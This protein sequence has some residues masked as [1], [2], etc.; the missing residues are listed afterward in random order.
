[1]HRRDFLQTG[2]AA[3]ATG[4]LTPAVVASGTVLDVP[5][6]RAN[7]PAVLKSYTADDHRRRLQNIGVCTQ[8]VR[9]C[10]RKH[11]VTNYLPAQCA[12]NLGEYPCVKPWNPDVYDEQELDRLRDHGIQLVQLFDESNDSLRLFGGSKHTPLNPEGLRRFVAMAHRRGIRVIT[13]LSTGYF[14]YKD[15][16]LKPEWYRQGDGVTVGYWDM[17]RCSPASP[18]WR[19]P[20]APCCPAARR[21]WPRRSL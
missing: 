3:A 15:P 7:A 12:Y 10:M 2:A 21:L 20:V 1:M 17:V 14:Q 4:A 8:A 5:A 11:L 9:C 18:G 19:L 13:Y 6:I 16:D